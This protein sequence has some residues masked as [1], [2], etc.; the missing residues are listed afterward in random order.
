[1]V[2]TKLKNLKPLLGYHLSKRIQFVTLSLTH[3]LT[4]SI[5][6]HD[7]YEKFNIGERDL[8]TCF[9]MGDF[10]EVTKGVIANLGSSAYKIID[11]ELGQGTYQLWIDSQPQ[12]S[13][14]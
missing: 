10:C 8:D 3:Q 2:L 7:Y 9:R 13:L 4:N 14:F 6:R 5:K 11:N 12:M 1:M